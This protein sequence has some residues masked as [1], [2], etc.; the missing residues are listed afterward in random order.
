VRRILSM[1]W[2]NIDRAVI[3]GQRR[4]FAKLGCAVA[5]IDATGTAHGVWIDSV[6]TTAQ[7]DDIILF[8]DIDAFPLT[9]AVVERAFAAAE[10]GRIFGVAQA[11]NHLPERNFLYA[12]P[13]FLCLS[14]RCW[15]AI[16]RPSA[17]DDDAN[18]VAMRIG[19]AAVA[20]G[21]TTE[22][23]YPNYVTVPRWRLGG[24][25]CTGYGTFYGEG[26]VFHLFE[27]RKTRRAG[28]RQIFDHVVARTVAGEEVD[29]VALYEQSLSAR[30]RLSAI[31]LY[32]RRRTAKTIRQASR[33]RGRA[34]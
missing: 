28:L 21:V 23:L 11:A 5:Q 7:P 16:G 3:E 29:Y 14:R 26:S 6:M 9:A 22:L 15:E 24:K 13:A 8:V 12:G 20:H 31:W 4:V 19:R 32:L 17:T 10:A 34:R 27:A 2:N 30:F 33:R 1:Y 18:D 25:G